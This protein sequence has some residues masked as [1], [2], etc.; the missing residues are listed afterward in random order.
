MH[1]A[2]AS[3]TINKQQLRETVEKFSGQRA[4]TEVSKR[5]HFTFDELENHSNILAANFV[6]LGFGSAKNITTM[7]N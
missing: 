6:S 1:S 4:V 3:V 5:K 7:K 2:L